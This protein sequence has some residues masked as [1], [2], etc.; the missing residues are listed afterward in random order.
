MPQ[1]VTRQNIEEI[2]SSWERG[3]LTA[4]QVF[5]WANDRFCVSTWEIDSEV[6]NEVLAIL[7]TM[8]INL[9]VKADIPVLRAALNSVT[10]EQAIAELERRLPNDALEQRLRE[11]A[12]DPFYVA[13]SADA[14]PFAANTTALTSRDPGLK[15]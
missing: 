4:R 10:V 14:Q 11:C 5:D 6:S 13:A 9:V 12:E 7:D 15:R 8:N 3:V 2:L 1:I